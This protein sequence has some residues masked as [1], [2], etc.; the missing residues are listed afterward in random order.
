M[1]AVKP[2]GANPLI[3]EIK[4]LV[5]ET[6][7]NDNPVFVSPIASSKIEEEDM[8]IPLCT[9]GVSEF[10]RFIRFPLSNESTAE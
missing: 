1:T 10:F 8:L 9:D 4:L 2:S 3:D 7:V 5:G 6:R